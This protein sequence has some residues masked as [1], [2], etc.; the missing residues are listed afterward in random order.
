MSK[1]HLKQLQPSTGFSLLYELHQSLIVF[2]YGKIVQKKIKTKLRQHLAVKT[3]FLI[4]KWLS[5]REVTAPI[6][7]KI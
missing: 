3:S 1:L 5:H 2:R 4:A 6:L 7:S